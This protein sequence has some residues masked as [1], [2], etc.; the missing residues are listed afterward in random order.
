MCV[1]VV[2]CEFLYQT[3]RHF[4]LASKC[5]YKCTKLYDREEVPSDHHNS[6][7]SITY[8]F[9]RFFFQGAAFCWTGNPLVKTLVTTD[10]SDSSFVCVC[11]C[12][13]RLSEFAFT[14]LEK[15]VNEF[16]FNKS[17][18]QIK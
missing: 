3:H 8:I 1:A 2:L 13:H 14:Y 5:L 10:F 9:L 7:N 6:E 15:N 11:V 17:Q 18:V 16:Y 4:L 12:V